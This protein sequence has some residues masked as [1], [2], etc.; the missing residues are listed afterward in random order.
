M[1]AHIFYRLMY[2]IAVARVRYWTPII[3]GQRRLVGAPHPGDS[4]RL[5]NAIIARGRWLRKS[6]G[7]WK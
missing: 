2:W 6:E 1:I 7:T 3:S 4:S 5:T